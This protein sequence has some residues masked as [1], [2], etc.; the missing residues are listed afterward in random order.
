[1]VVSGQT[2]DFLATAGAGA[3]VEVLDVTA[4]VDEFALAAAGGIAVPGVELV[5]RR[6]VAPVD[7]LAPAGVAVVVGEG[8]GALVA[9]GLVL[10]DCEDEGGRRV[11]VC[12]DCADDQ[13]VE[14]ALDVL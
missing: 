4:E 14:A 2:C 10:R 6:A 3:G 9:L 1:M 8:R 12:V 7:A 13:L 11:L 5:H